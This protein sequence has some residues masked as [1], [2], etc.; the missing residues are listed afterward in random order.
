MFTKAFEGLDA[1]KPEDLGRFRLNREFVKWM[2]E[3]MKQWTHE[4]Q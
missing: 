2:K 4:E 3:R 1:A